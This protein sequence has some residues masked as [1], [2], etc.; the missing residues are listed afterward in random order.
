MFWHKSYLTSFS[1]FSTKLKLLCPHTKTGTSNVL[2]MIK[3]IT[4]MSKQGCDPNELKIEMIRASVGGT[5]GG[6]VQAMMCWC[7][8]LSPWSIFLTQSHS[9]HIAE[10]LSNILLLPCYCLLFHCLCVRGA[11]VLFLSPNVSLLI[12]PF[13]CLLRGLFIRRLPNLLIFIFFI[14]I[15]FL[16]TVI[17]FFF[18]WCFCNN[19][20]MFVSSLT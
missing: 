20:L 15:S 5:G 6:T 9:N 4:C 10:T 14:R 2:N 18:F 16:F 12:A 1:H 17:I 7:N 11:T 19:E 13:A 8:E 3:N